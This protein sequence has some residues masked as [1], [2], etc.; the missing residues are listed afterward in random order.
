MMQATNLRNRYDGTRRRLL[1]FPVRRRVLLQ[2]QV[3]AAFVIIGQKRFQGR[4]SGTS[5]ATIRLSR[6]S[7][8]IVPVTHAGVGYASRVISGLSHFD[9]VSILSLN[10]P[11]AT[12]NEG[13]VPGAW[14]TTHGVVVEGGIQKR[15]GRLRI[16]PELRYNTGTNTR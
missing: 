9:E 7:L 6:H 10:P 16:A 4:S 15:T 2:R 14:D 13:F 1:H 5:S 3:R 8:R 11:L 12:Y